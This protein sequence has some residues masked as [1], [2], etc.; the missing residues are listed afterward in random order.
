MYVLQLPVLL[1]LYAGSVQQ[2]ANAVCDGFRFDETMM[3]IRDASSNLR[4]RSMNSGGMRVDRIDTV[5][6]CVM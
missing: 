4:N 1:L 3:H 2:C 6:V 5:L